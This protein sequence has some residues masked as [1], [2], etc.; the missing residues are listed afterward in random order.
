MSSLI[1]F[2]CAERTPEEQK[3]QGSVRAWIISE[4]N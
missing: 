4:S 3:K 1:S 2:E